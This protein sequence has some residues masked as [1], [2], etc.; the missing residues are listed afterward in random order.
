LSYRLKHIELALAEN[1]NVSPEDMPAFRARLRHLRNLG[2]PAIRAS[3]SG[4]KLDY[5]RK[6]AVQLLVALEMELMGM[7][8]Q[9]AA[10][11]SRAAMQM[12]ISDAEAAARK[13]WRLYMSVAPDFASLNKPDWV[14]LG[15]AAPDAEPVAKG[16]YRRAFVDIATSIKRLDA[17]LKRLVGEE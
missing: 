2:V 4:K 12:W 9:H 3:G 10:A 17:S 13:N 15:K 14:F 7:A 16:A 5:E 6:H 8:A 11:Y 1:F